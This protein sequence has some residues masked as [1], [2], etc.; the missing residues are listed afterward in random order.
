MDGLRTR[1]SRH[2][3]VLRLLTELPTAI[4]GKTVSGKIIGA[5]PGA[6][7]F[8]PLFVKDNGVDFDQFVEAIREIGLFWAV[9]NEPPPGSI[10]RN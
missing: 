5:L 2:C 9:L 3:V 10:T 7:D 6:D 8:V 4:E 1:L